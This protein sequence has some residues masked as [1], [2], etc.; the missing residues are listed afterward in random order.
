[1]TLIEERRARR[2][3]AIAKLELSAAGAVRR[4]DRAGS[5][6]DHFER[7]FDLARLPY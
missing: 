1:M 2:D 5:R 6:L 7:R 3:V 4:I